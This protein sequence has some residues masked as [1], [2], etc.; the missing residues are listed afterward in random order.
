VKR[1]AGAA[2][3]FTA[4]AMAMTW[5][6]A[7]IITR[8]VAYPADP[9]HLTWVLDWD[10]FA[11]LHRPLQLFQANIFYPVKDAFAYSEHLYGMAVFLF[12]LR[13]AGI[14]ALTAHNIAVILGFAFSGFAAYLLGRTLTGNTVAGIAA[15]IFYAYLPW[16]MT[17]LPHTHNLWAG[18]LPL[19]V[20]ALVHCARKPGRRSAA[21][22]GAVFLLNGLSNLHYFVFGSTAIL[23]SVPLLVRDRKQLLRIGAATLMAYALIA[24]FLIPYFRLARETGLRRSPAEVTSWS[25]TPQD[26]LNP[27]ATNRLYR[28][29][30]DPKPDPER[31]LFPGVIG[32][33][34]SC[35]GVYAARRRPHAL[36]LGLLWF[37]LGFVGSLGLHT[38]FHRFLFDHVPGFS[39]LRVPAR[40]ANVA[41]VG[42]TMLVAFGAAWRKWIGVLAAA[43]FIVELNAA[44]IRWH[45]T[46]PS[47][48]PVYRWLR[49]QRGPIAELPIGGER[50]FQYLRFATEHHLQTVN[51]VSSFVPPSF[52]ELSAKWED[53]AKR[54]ALL[55][56]L[57]ATGV[58]LVILHGDALPP[59]ERAWLRRAIDEGRLRFLQ[60]FDDD[61]VFRFAG[62]PIASADLDG[63]LRGEP[64]RY[65]STFGMLEEPQPN[66]YM[67]YKAHFS[68]WATSPH[69]VRQVNLLFD[70]GGV[71][72]PATVTGARFA[73]QF[74]QRPSDI[75]RDTDVQVEIVDGRR[76]RTLLEGRWIWWGP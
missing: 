63:Y 22:F 33:A 29:I 13:M 67:R 71:R 60:R 49:T 61:W 9:Y 3:F 53:P 4:L 51:G 15:G 47:V 35:V 6:L 64:T 2:A 12:P 5:P 37:V 56:D 69:G 72:V 48:P 34:M 26:W 32:I 30:F 31:W 21:L 42:M 8:G 18:W 16:R 45:C 54:D 43:V 1:D 41:Y 70:N 7:R 57:R 14:S 68:G 19:L 50:E 40:W 10:W 11:T 66:A 23:F 52:F 58:R 76:E 55:A 44:P 24:P 62:G 28:R 59:P 73:A 20:V 74:I 65:E 36:A 38:F 25:A 75:R 27:G 39:A 46:S 17:Q